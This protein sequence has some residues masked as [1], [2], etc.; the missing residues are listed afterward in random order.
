MLDA[1][2]GAA[3]ATREEPTP[4]FVVPVGLS[5][6]QQAL[7]PPKQRADNA[8]PMPAIALPGLEA[9]ISNHFWAAGLRGP[10]S[11]HV[12]VR[13]PTTLP[14]SPPVLVVVPLLV[15][16]YSEVFCVHWVVWLRALVSMTGAAIV[17]EKM[18][19]TV[20]S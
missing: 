5:S 15:Q 16:Q 2:A 4:L 6:P 11:V 7:L 20:R 19:R 17:M 9:Q 10:F 1:S 8:P 12:T 13:S 3:Y 14:M 18:E